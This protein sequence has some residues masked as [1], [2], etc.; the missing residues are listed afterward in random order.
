MGTLRG[1]GRSREGSDPFAEQ[2]ALTPDDP[3]CEEHPRVAWIYCRPRNLVDANLG[4]HDFSVPG[5]LRV[6]SEP[7]LRR[8]LTPSGQNAMAVLN[9]T[10]RGAL[11]CRVR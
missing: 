3:S 5:T 4:W 11:R 6:G 2:R 7:F 8:D 1:C 9:I 10:C